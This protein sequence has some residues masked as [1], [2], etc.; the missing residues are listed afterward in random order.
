MQRKSAGG[1]A[2]AFVTRDASSSRRAH[3]RRTN[4]I[5]DRGRDSLRIGCDIGNVKWLRS[6]AEFSDVAAGVL[7]MGDHQTDRGSELR[8]EWGAHEPIFITEDSTEHWRIEL[9]CTFHKI[10]FDRVEIGLMVA[11]A[12]TESDE[13]EVRPW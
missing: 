6:L 1:K 13:H 11:T 2:S 4:D 7:R 3:L 10:R 9:T 8:E 5:E 12:A